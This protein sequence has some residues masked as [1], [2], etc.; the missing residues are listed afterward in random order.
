MVACC[1]CN[2]QRRFSDD[3]Q[4]LE[5]QGQGKLSSAREVVCEGMGGWWQEESAEGET[6]GFIFSVTGTWRTVD[7]VR[8]G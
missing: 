2:L 1:H 7:L 6:V 5:E 4:D 3:E 8:A